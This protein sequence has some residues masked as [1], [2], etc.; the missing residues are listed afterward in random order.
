MKTRGNSKSDCLRGT[1]S[2]MQ[3]SVIE[4]NLQ[5]LVIILIIHFISIELHKEQKETQDTYSTWS[6]RVN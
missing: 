3:M 6:M 1:K 4:C 5:F 2:K